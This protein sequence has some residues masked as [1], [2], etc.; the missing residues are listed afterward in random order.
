VL[1]K[2]ITILFLFLTISLPL[3]EQI[4]FIPKE[5]VE[6]QMGKI[7]FYLDIQNQQF[8]EQL[9][10]KCIYYE[11]IKYP[12]IVLL[13]AQLETGFYTS[14]IFSNGKNCFGMKFPQYRETLAAGT[15]QEHAQ[16]NNWWES[17]QDYKIWQDWYSSLGYKIN[18]IND[19]DFYLVFLRCVRYAEDPYYIHKL[20]YLSQKDLA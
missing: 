7:L 8:S 18:T 17:V 2:K 4:V 11:R 9:L 16:Y 12:E 19:N 5:E 10:K 6:F 1:L 14:D 20:V 15:Y 13:Q 3:K